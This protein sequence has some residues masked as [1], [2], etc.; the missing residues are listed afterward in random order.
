MLVTGANKGIGLA[1]TRGLCKL[2]GDNVVYLGSRNEE[3]GK[4]AVKLLEGEGLTPRLLLI[5]IDDED[6]VKAARDFISA[7]HGGLSVLVNNAG[8]A[9]KHDSK[10]SFGEQA[11]VTVR[12]NYYGTQRVCNLMFPLLRPGARV[13]NVSSSC[14]KLS[15]IDGNDCQALREKFRDPQ[16]TEAGLDKLMEDFI[17]LAKDSKEAATKAGYPKNTYKVSKVGVSALT[18]IQQREMDRDRGGEDIAINH[19]HPGYVDTDMTS[20]KGS[21][22]IDEG[23][24]SSLFAATLPPG[25]DIRG[26][27][28]WQ[29]CSVVKWD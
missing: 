20:H 2:P 3:R 14:G 13:V 28:I 10:A 8:I 7:T 5:D 15:M 1:I 4:K 26:E 17:K 27:Y 23:A 19:V 18:I 11:A 25:T 9:F 22:T 21:L 12:T 29:D 6:S 24:S 16:L